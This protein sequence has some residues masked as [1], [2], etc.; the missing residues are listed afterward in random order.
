MPVTLTSPDL[1][2]AY[3]PGDLV[4]WPVRDGFK[5]GVVFCRTPSIEVSGMWTRADWNS[6]F[7]GQGLR[8]VI[9]ATHR[10]ATYCYDLCRRKLPWGGYLLFRN[11]L[12]L[13]GKFVVSISCGHR[14]TR[15]GRVPSWS[16]FCRQ[17]GDIALMRNKDAARLRYVSF[18]DERSSRFA[19]RFDS[20]CVGDDYARR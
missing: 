17:L 1:L 20:S 8:G 15:I 11:H 13:K 18:F 6:W 5:R 16:V 2:D 4:E 7:N 12:D 14:L 3:F 10:P 19:F 9:K